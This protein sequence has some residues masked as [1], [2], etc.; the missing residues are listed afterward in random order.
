ML[1]RA[2]KGA[3]AEKKGQ[4]ENSVLKGDMPQVECPQE[5]QHAS[6]L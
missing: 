4:H 3:G 2:Y 6:A 5:E 1:V